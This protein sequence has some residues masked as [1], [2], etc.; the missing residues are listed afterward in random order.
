V[1][2][3]QEIQLRSGQ[4]FRWYAVGCQICVELVDF[5]LRLHFRLL[6]EGH[7]THVIYEDFDKVATIGTFSTT[8]IVHREWDNVT[9][10]SFS[11]HSIHSFSLI[12][13]MASRAFLQKCKFW[14]EW[15]CIFFPF[16]SLTNLQSTHA[17]IFTLTNTY[18]HIHT[19]TNTHAQTHH[20]D[21][22]S[23]F[24]THRVIH[25]VS[26]TYTKNQ[27]HAHT[28]STHTRRHTHTH[29]FLQF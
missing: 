19:L 28:W 9:L 6:D 18:T 21:T 16:L 2:I 5:S 14:S 13:R 10:P 17:R 11:I 8:A 1:I 12:P 22:L 24:H 20:T 25:T 4:C 23:L 3:L 26:Q 7:V 15:I 29:M 27:T